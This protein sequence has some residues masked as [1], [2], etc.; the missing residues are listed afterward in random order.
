MPVPAV[1]GIYKGD[2]DDMADPSGDLL[3]APRAEVALAGS[4]RLDPS[5]LGARAAQ[6]IV[7]QDGKRSASSGA[8][9]PGPSHTSS[10]A[11]D[12]ADPGSG[13]A[14]RHRSGVVPPVLRLLAARC[15]TTLPPGAPPLGDAVWLMASGGC[16]LVD[17]GRSRSRLS[18][19]ILSC[20]ARPGAGE[21]WCWPASPRGLRCGWSPAPRQPRAG[22]GR[23]H[24]RSRGARA[25]CARARP[26]P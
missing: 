5:Q 16:R 4:E 17:G 26:C 24:R 12:E 1:L 13:P 6:R 9:M 14:D 3:I 8:V 19:M 22:A 11:D 15:Y 7:D 23:S 18:R 21:R 2:D 25:R 10:I 20:A